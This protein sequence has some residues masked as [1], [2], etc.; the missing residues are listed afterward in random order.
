MRMRYQSFSIKHQPIRN[1]AEKRL[2][3]RVF[4]K[5]GGKFKYRI[6]NEDIQFKN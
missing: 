1:T 4:R 6:Q 2:R 3:M 5:Y